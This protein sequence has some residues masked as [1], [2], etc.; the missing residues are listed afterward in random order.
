MPDGTLPLKDWSK[1]ELLVKISS[2]LKEVEQLRYENCQLYSRLE[3]IGAVVGGTTIDVD[4]GCWT[5][6][7]LKNVRKRKDESKVSK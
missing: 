6:Q 3:A 4:P 2:A 7:Y 1:D 5:G